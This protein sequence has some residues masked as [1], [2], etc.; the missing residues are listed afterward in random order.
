[1]GKDRSIV[2]QLF[3]FNIGLEAGQI[4][5]VGIFLFWSLILVDVFT[6][7]RRDWKLVIS[8]IIA[9]MVI[10]VGGLTESVAKQS[11]ASLLQLVKQAKGSTRISELGNSESFISWV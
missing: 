9:G 5:I 8:S 7:N 10:S 11:C 1:M 4:I 6:V 3:A 2:T